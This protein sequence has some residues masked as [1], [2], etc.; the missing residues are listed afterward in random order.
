[1]Q[2][3]EHHLQRP[4]RHNRLESPE[5]HR[6]HGILRPGAAGPSLPGT[7]G[8]A[9][10]E[11][12]EASSLGVIGSASSGIRGVSLIAVSGSSS[13]VTAG[14]PPHE[15]AGA[16]VHGADNVA[17]TPAVGAPYDRKSLRTPTQSA[18]LG[19][20]VETAGNRRAS[21]L[22]IRI[23]NLWESQS[24]TPGTAGESSPG[25]VGTATYVIDPASFGRNC[26]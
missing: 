5:R 26:R 7:E 24:T 10:P 23:T 25:A 22:G 1:M 13:P 21:S 2:I 3:G 20:A 15:V 6:A 4:A 9:S 12:N 19:V 8:E 18:P 17:L 16:S 11:T 14:A